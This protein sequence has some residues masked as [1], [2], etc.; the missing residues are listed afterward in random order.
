M[1]GLRLLVL[2]MC[3]GLWAGSIAASDT[4]GAVEELFLGELVFPQE[5][6]E[7]QVGVGADIGDDGSSWS[8]LMEWGLRDGWQLE[9]ELDGAF[10][11]DERGLGT[12]ELGARYAVL[13]VTPDFHL[14]L[15]ASLSWVA[16]DLDEAPRDTV[17]FEPS[18]VLARDVADGRGHLFAQIGGEWV[19]DEGSPHGLDVGEAEDAWEWVFGG[20]RA[21]PWGVGVLEVQG[22]RDV[23]GEEEAEWRAALGWVFKLEVGELGVAR[24]VTLEGADDEVWMIRWVVELDGD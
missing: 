12:V 20:Y 23:A 9:L 6:G 14:A 15:G 21:T 24:T 16:Q 19:V 7:L 17:F 2:S 22:E 10:D 3:L 18:V 13:D 11:G 8:A 1:T 5:A 4:E